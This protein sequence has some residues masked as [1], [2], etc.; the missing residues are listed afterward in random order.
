VIFKEALGVAL[1]KYLQAS[2]PAF[3]EIPKSSAKP[4]RTGKKNRTAP[5][6]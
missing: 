3:I 2:I 4:L 1:R 5:F 6:P